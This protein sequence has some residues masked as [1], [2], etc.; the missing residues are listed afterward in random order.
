MTTLDIFKRISSNVHKYAQGGTYTFEGEGWSHT[1]GTKNVKFYGEVQELKRLANRED[2]K[3]EE[4]GA[5]LHLVFVDGT[6][7][8]E[9]YIIYEPAQYVGRPDK[10][11]AD[12]T[13]NVTIANQ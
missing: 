9:Y 6:T 11:Q 12:I 5:S 4:H 13:Y 2:V 10:I 3:S 7:D 1:V 8:T